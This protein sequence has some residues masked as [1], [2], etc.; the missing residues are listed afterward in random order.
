MMIQLNNIVV[1]QEEVRVA[2]TVGVYNHC[3]RLTDGMQ[4]ATSGSVETVMVDKSN[5]MLLGPTGNIIIFFRRSRMMTMTKD[6]ILSRD[7]KSKYFRF[8][9]AQKCDWVQENYFYCICNQH[10]A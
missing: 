2:L 7:E 6:P 9:I 10:I 8:T 4:I 3:K 5:I 1:G